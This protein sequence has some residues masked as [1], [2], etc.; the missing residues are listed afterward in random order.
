[1]V[2]VLRPPPLIQVR[3]ESAAPVNFAPVPDLHN[4]HYEH[5]IHNFVD[6]AIH[7]LAD[8]I[9][10]LTRQLLAARRARIIG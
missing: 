1:M 3:V 9:S 8:P 2:S 7:S 6:D 4:H 5:V 10:F